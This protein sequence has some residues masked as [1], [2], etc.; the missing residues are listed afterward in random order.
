MVDAKSF[1]LE[2]SL[3]ILLAFQTLPKIPDFN[4]YRLPPSVEIDGETTT[5]STMDSAARW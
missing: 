1:R 2:F 4:R 3:Q 5:H